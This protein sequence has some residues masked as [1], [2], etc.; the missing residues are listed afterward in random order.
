[1]GGPRLAASYGYTADRRNGTN[2]LATST[3]HALAALVNV[4]GCFQEMSATV[5]IPFDEVR[6]AETGE[7][8]ANTSPSQVVIDGMLT[9]G[10]T[11]SIAV[12]G[13]TPLSAPRFSITVVGEEATVVV[14]PAALGDSINVGDWRITRFSAEAGAEPVEPAPETHPTLAGLG[15]PARNVARMY[16]RFGHALAQ[17]Q[18]PVPD[19]AV[20][21]ALHR[22][23]GTIEKA[24][25]SGNRQG[26]AD[27]I[28]R[29][30]P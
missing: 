7:V 30:L 10:A 20:A 25:V 26:V 18:R 14:E 27:E 4:A 21:V 8:L 2:M 12:H 11:A 16:D 24:A 22:L 17:A 13:G 19:F 1:M 9:S 6:I 23:I 29:A 5:G 28:L 3:A 15:A